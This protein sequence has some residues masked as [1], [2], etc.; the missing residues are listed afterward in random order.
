MLN[1]KKLIDIGFSGLKKNHTIA[2]VQK[3]FNVPE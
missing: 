1:P 2:L 3:L